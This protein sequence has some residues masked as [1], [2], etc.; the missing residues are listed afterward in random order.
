M[1]TTA[2]DGLC[3]WSIY[4]GRPYI[5]LAK[6][7]MSFFRR[8]MD[9][10][11]EMA[12]AVL[13]RHVTQDDLK[14]D[15]DLIEAQAFR[16][17]SAFLMQQPRSRL[18]LASPNLSGLLMLKDRWRVSVKAMIR[19]CSDLKL[20]SSG[21]AVQ[22]YKYY[23]AK[24]WS[25]EEPMDRVVPVAKAASA[26]ASPWHDRR[27]WDADERGAADKRVH[28]FAARYRGTHMSGRRLVRCPDGPSRRAE[29]RWR[30]GNVI[31]VRRWRGCF[32]F[33]GEAD[34]VY[35]PLIGITCPLGSDSAA[36]MALPI[37]FEATRKGS[38]S[39]C[40]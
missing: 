21:D 15:F 17:A 30:P 4:D 9:A 7:K 36:A 40:A 20:I 8:Q 1:G 12:H 31:D 5:L 10:A 6:D 34:A 13:H 37:L 27:W 29:A 22:L 32:L 25:R 3:N 33:S 28:R 18:K 24:G 23:S 39:R 38:A 14:A 16:L 35:R 26:G 11:H 19:R 2:L